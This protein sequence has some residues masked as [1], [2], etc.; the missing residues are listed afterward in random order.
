[1]IA[2][3]SVEEKTGGKR[4]RRRGGGWEWLRHGTTFFT[5]IAAAREANSECIRFLKNMFYRGRVLK[6]E[7]TSVAR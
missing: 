3:V 7:L 4:L 5:Q 6:R 1:M 2:A